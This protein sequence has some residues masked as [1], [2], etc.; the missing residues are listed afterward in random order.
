MVLL[1]W[2]GVGILCKR[3]RVL[4]SW[5]PFPKLDGKS[6]EDGLTLYTKT[7]VRG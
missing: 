1:G 7:D 2:E 5:H 6:V 3:G 4:N